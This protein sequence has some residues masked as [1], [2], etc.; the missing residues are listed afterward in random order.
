MEEVGDETRHMEARAG[1]GIMMGVMQCELCDFRNIMQ[2][3]GLSLLNGHR[4]DG[5]YPA[6][7]L[8]WLLGA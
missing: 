7:N 8:G 4:I 2:Q 1:N 5:V 6:G 3:P